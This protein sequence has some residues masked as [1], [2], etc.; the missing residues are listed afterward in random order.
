MERQKSDRERYEEGVKGVRET[1]KG[2]K[3]RWLNSFLYLPF[4]SLSRLGTDA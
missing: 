1:E 2:L 3:V 4:R